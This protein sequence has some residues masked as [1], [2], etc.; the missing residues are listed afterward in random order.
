MLTI[1]KDLS[2]TIGLQGTG[3]TASEVST[4]SCSRMAGLSI[5]AWSNRLELAFDS[6]DLRDLC[7]HSGYAVETFGAGVAEQLMHRVADMMAAPSPLDLIAGNR[8]TSSVNQDC[9]VLD[10]CDGFEIEFRANHVSIPT[11]HR[12]QIDWRKVN[13][14]KIIRIGSIDNA[15]RH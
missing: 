5:F 3:P 9:L 4:V 12:G 15:I 10:L 14:V 13:R 1:L 8:R 11:D 2:P 7:E 6:R